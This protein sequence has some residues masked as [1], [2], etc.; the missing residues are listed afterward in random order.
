MKHKNILY[1]FTS[2]F[3]IIC[4]VVLSTLITIKSNKKDDY[5]IILGNLI[6]EKINLPNCNQSFASNFM[7]VSYLEKMIKNDASKII[8]N[9]IVKLSKLI[10]DASYIIINIGVYDLCSNIKINETTNTLIYDEEVLKQKKQIIISIVNTIINDIHTI[11]QNLIV[12]L[13]NVDYNYKIHDYEL[14]KIFNELN[15]SYK[16]LTNNY[17][18]KTLN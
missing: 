12:Y 15:Q 8:N 17:N 18:I 3:L 9:K 10:K 7:S 2:V 6:E 1:I 5:G 4:I 14:I 13:K 16:N 11:N